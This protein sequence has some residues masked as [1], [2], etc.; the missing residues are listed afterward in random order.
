MRH[1]AVREVREIFLPMWMG[2][3]FPS[4]DF[5]LIVLPMCMVVCMELGTMNKPNLLPKVMGRGK[6][7]ISELVAIILTRALACVRGAACATCAGLRCLVRRSC[8]MGFAGGMGDTCGMGTESASRIG[9]V[10]E[11]VV[12]PEARGQA[13]PEH[14]RSAVGDAR[15]WQGHVQRPQVASSGADTESVA[16]ASCARSLL[17]SWRRR[18]VGRR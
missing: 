7:V 14:R 16:C 11:L 5:E 10:A 4:A 8:R 3:C 13:R 18:G 17:C 9:R 15:A 2:V 1:A 6:L 12:A